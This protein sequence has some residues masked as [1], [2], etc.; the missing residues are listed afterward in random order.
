MLEIDQDHDSAPRGD[1]ITDEEVAAHRQ[2]GAEL[3]F[4]IDRAEYD[5]LD[6]VHWSKLKLMRKAAALYR[7]AVTSKHVDTDAMKLGRAVHLALLEPTRFHSECVLWDAGPRRGKAWEKFKRDNSDREI[8]TEREF[9]LCERLSSAVHS[10]AEARRHLTNARTEATILWRAYG[11][12][13][14]ALPGWSFNLKS[15]LDAITSEAIADLKTC[16]DGSM[17]GFGRD[18]IRH[19]YHAQ[20]AFYSDAYTAATGVR[21]PYV[22]VTV[23]TSAPYLVTLYRVTDEQIEEGRRIYRGCLEQ[24][25]FCVRENRW[26]GYAEGVQSL[27]MPDWALPKDEDEVGDLDL[28]IGT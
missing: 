24:L 6:R 18:A 22:L 15:R 23:E 3:R 2:P 17:H 20:A 26:P 21:L 27:A 10:D 9:E 7:H 12:S 11:E 19:G 13:S 16:R 28:E 8:L 1:R 5:R 25:G 14:D 4:D